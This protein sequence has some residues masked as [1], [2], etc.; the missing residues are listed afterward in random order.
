MRSDQ[1]RVT[2]HLYEHDAVQ[3]VVPMGGGKTV[4]TLTAI[5]ELIDDGVIRCALLLAPKRVAHS[6]WPNEIAAWS[7]LKDTTY[8]EIT[9]NAAQREAALATHADIYLCGK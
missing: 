1:V 6:V 8:I 7:H 4:S 5:R 9:G 3:A 2:T